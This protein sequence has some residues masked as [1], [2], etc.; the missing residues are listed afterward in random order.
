MIPQILEALLQQVI[1]VF[2]KPT[3]HS[4]VALLIPYPGWW[5]V[6]S[7]CHINLPYGLP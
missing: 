6:D 5:F 7:L 3:G 4:G 1:G 2:I